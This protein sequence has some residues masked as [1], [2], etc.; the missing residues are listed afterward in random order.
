M[1]RYG[2]APYLECSS[3]GDKRFSAFYAQVGGTSIEAQYQAAKIFEGG[4]TGL[5]WRKAK[6]KQ[7]TNMPDVIDLYDRLWVQYI[8]ENIHLLD[9][10]KT[11]SGLSDIF[12]TPGRQC[13]AEVLWRIRNGELAI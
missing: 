11:S 4:Q 8:Q 2:E 1:L 3:K 9:I 5:H 7:A 6:G 10:L 12:G 13:Q